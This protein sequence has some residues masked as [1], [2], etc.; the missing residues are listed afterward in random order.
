MHLFIVLL[1]LQVKFFLSFKSISIFN[2]ISTSNNSFVAVEYSDMTTRE[3]TH[4]SSVITPRTR[5]DLVA[6]ECFYFSGLL[7]LIFRLFK[8]TLLMLL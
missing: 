8:G 5:Q 6:I 7:K 2:R 3:Y 4:M 1:Q